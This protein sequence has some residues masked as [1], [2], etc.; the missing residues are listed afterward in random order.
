MSRAYVSFASAVLAALAVGG[1]APSGHGLGAPIPNAASS[2]VVW[3]GVELEDGKDLAGAEI[4]EIPVR[5][6]DVLRLEAS[7][8]V[9]IGE[10]VRSGKGFAETWSTLKPQNGFVTV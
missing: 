10:R 4:D 5:G 9:E 8:P 3:N 2:R 7:G 1:C 6:G